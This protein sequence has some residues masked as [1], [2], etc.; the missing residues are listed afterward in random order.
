MLK[1]KCH[2]IELPPLRINYFIH[3]YTGYQFLKFVI[4]FL[5]IRFTNKTKLEHHMTDVHIGGGSGTNAVSNAATN[6]C[7]ICGGHFPDADHL[8]R[9][10]QKPHPIACKD[11]QCR[12]RFCTDAAL[13]KHLQRKHKEFAGAK[14]AEDGRVR[15]PCRLCGASF[16][17][18]LGLQSHQHVD[19][20][21]GEGEVFSSLVEL[22]TV[23]WFLSIKY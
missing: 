13:E 9:H 22:R 1:N 12:R 18:H 15:F 11:G 5:T 6:E 4:I 21:A 23:N 19:H 3:E 14:L 8:R 10:R 16:D 20:K 17:H 2:L 7:D